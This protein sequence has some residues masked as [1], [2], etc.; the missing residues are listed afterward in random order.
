VELP[1]LALGD[2]AFA[3]FLVMLIGG[4]G[5]LV[6]QKVDGRNQRKT[7]IVLLPSRIVG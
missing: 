2:F 7:D 3:D 4:G 5:C 1:S 6:A